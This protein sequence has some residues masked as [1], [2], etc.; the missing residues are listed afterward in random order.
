M[1]SFCFVTPEAAPACVDETRSV[2][3]RANAVVTT[4]LTK[5]FGSRLAVDH[6]DLAIPAGA[7]S[8]FVG[9]NGAG[10]TTTI[11]MLLGLV[12]PSEGSGTVLGHRL[13]DHRA[14]LKRVGALI[15]GPTFYATLSA[16]EN[17]A[18]LARLA[19]IDTRRV[20]EALERVGL[21]ARRNDQFR[22][23][24]LGMRQ[25][26]GIAA[27]LVP[28]PDLL[29]LDEPT[30]GLDPHGIP[31]IRCLLRQFADEGMTVFVSSHLLAEIQQICDHLVVIDSG[32]LLFQGSVRQLL[33]KSS[34]ALVV[35]PEGCA[36]ALRL[37][38]LV[39]RHGRCGKLV[40]DPANPYVEVGAEPGWA[41]ELNR[42]AMAEGITL[43]HLTERSTTLEEAFFEIMGHRAD[44]DGA[45][46][47]ISTTAG[48]DPS[49]SSPDALIA[50]KVEP[51][52]VPSTAGRVA[53]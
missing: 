36:D 47:G 15:E 5:R 23:F 17:L 35:R 13:G 10:K 20:D 21:S 31:E 34:P 26:L 25:R 48:T 43:C 40:G 28:H 32:S 3:A 49:S 4:G 24:S 50:E 8:G 27:A 30:N 46:A 41:A 9:P 52:P 14:Y 18:V 37:L 11:R 42:L 29:V 7:I 19:G 45:R 38:A 33:E 53:S 51:V 44:P 39:Q 22:T 2:P 12:R 1:V 16:R 6:L